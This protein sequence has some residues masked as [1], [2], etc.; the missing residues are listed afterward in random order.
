M[1]RKLG[2]DIEHEPYNNDDDTHSVNSAQTNELIDGYQEANYSP[3]SRALSKFT[4]FDDLN[5]GKGSLFDDQYKMMSRK[6]S[7]YG[8]V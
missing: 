6:F 4:D 7:F 8:P 5:L 2:V 3:R 1:E